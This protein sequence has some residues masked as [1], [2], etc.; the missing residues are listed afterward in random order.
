MLISLRKQVHFPVS[1]VH[2]CTCTPPPRAHTRLVLTKQPAAPHFSVTMMKGTCCSQQNPPSP[3]RVADILPAL[4]T[5][6]AV[7]Q[8][9][10]RVTPDFLTRTEEEM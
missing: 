5:S 9:L 2:V 8:S 4:F 3:P 10:L 1:L 6:R 7:T